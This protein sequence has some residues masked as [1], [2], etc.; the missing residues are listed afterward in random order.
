MKLLYIKGELSWIIVPLFVFLYLYFKK[1]RSII[2]YPLLLVSIIG[3][4]H[5]IL[6]KNQILTYKLG[7][8]QF[9]LMI[10]FHLILLFPIYQYQKYSY[11]NF[12]SFLL[13]ILGIF[14]LKYLPWW[15]YPG[16]SRNYMISLT[17]ILY[18]ILNIIFF[19]LRNIQNF[20]NKLK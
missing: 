6:V 12:Y 10:L 4:W 15:P 1:S 7:L 19:F 17:I 20:K 14:I 5:L 2:F 16:F 3:I 18:V 11:P 8:I 13:I 9:I